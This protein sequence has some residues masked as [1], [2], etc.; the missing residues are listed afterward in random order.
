MGA[1]VSNHPATTS[2]IFGA[3]SIVVLSALAIV[4][5]ASFVHGDDLGAWV[6]FPYFISL[7]AAIFAIVF[8]V[9]GRRVAKVGAPG[10]VTATIG[11]ALG[12]AFIVLSILGVI[13]AL[14]AIS[15]LVRNDVL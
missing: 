14:I 1:D 12:I 2:L 7:V 4:L 10:Q 8:G 5:W 3:T 15:I 6:W 9:E 11:L 13:V